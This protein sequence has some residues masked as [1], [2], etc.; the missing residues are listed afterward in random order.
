[1][2]ILISV[3]PKRIELRFVSK[4]YFLRFMRRIHRALIEP[5]EIS[6]GSREQV[7]VEG[8]REASRDNLYYRFLSK[9]YVLRF[10]RRIHSALIKPIEISSGSREQVTGRFRLEGIRGAKRDRGSKLF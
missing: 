5:I 8:I 4:D 6:S 2:G 10:M 9:V 7:Q 1:M 3:C